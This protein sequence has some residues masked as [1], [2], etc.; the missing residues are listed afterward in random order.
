MVD[1]ARLQLEVDSRPIKKADRDL[2]KF[3]KASKTADRAAQNFSSTMSTLTRVLGAVGITIGTQQLLAF[4]NAALQASLNIERQA[5]TLGLTAE[6]FQR[7]AFAFRQFGADEA[8][9][10][11]VF[12][13][14]TDRA[15]D[16]KS[17][18]Q[19]F[20]DDFK[21]IGV[22]VDDLRGKNPQQLFTLFADAIG[23]AGSRNQQLTAAARILGDDLARRILPLIRNGAGAVRALGEEAQI[24]SNE[25][26]SASARM[27]EEVS[28]LSDQI[29]TGLNNAFIGFALE[30]EREI[31]LTFAAILEAAQIA[32]QQADNVSAAVG[33]G[34]LGR[35]I[36]GKSG[37][38]ALAAVAAG[39]VTE[40][41]DRFTD[42]Q[43]EALQRRIEAAEAMQQ[44]LEEMGAF[45]SPEMQNRYRDEIA[46]LEGMRLKIQELKEEMSLDPQFQE[47]FRVA[48]EQATAPLQ[49]AIDRLRSGPRRITIGDGNTQAQT[50][51][52]R[53]YTQAIRDQQKAIK[54]LASVDADFS[55]VVNYGTAVN[56]LAEL[57]SQGFISGERFNDLLEDQKRAL[58][59]VKDPAEE[60][61]NTLETLA[62]T[63]NDQV[64]QSITDMIFEAESAGD[65]L[66][67]LADQIA[68]TITQTLV[69]RPLV[70]GITG[71]VGSFFNIPQ[72]ANG[73]NVYGGAP[74]IVGERG[75]EL[76]VP[77][78]DGRIVPNHK[79]GGGGDVTV[80]IINEGGEPLEAQQRQT[81]RGP[82]GEMT[83]DV[84]VK[85]SMERLDAQGQLDG[86]FRRHGAARQG[87]F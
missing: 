8:D 67:G 20:I 37:P 48:A 25:T 71:Q 63:I 13:T 69:V 72:N 11:D 58:L 23:Q 2:D 74:S 54:D 24:A 49:D 85:S 42:N 36:F 68:R 46:Q 1:V 66:V 10:S 86:I 55:D 28:I 39:S 60:W 5:N 41:I 50:E 40:L 30:Y 52:A 79:M 59:D 34:I 65:I 33:G 53:D 18:M 26:V 70:E 75:P 31:K 35:I 16:A 21:L 47:E 7:I 56:R 9:V 44:G 4:G 29:R 87:Q 80:N 62:D 3:S 38:A 76:F 73:G 57:Y 77:N 17:G 78:Q 83:V 84:M 32:I 82:N 27:A 22:E 15:D 64:T 51:A 81:R 45:S 14:L 61:K 43:G 12:I 19:S 6:Q